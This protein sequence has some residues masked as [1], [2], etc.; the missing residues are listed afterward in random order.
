MAETLRPAAEYDRAQMNRLLQDGAAANGTNTARAAVHLLV[1]TRL[2]GTADFA[3]RVK[4]EL[5]SVPRRN[6]DTGD[7]YIE[8]VPTAWVQDWAALADSDAA[9]R[10][11]GGPQTLL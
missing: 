3:G 6:E 7:T 5:A 10:A 8:T 4:V 2:P 9:R 1:F 11:G